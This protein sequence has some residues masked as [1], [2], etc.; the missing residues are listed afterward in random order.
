[1]FSGIIEHTAKIVDIHDGTFTIENTFWEIL[2]EGQSVAH[3]GACMTITRCDE[4][5]YD[6]FVMHESLDV[7]H[8]SS[9]K[10][11]DTFNIERSLR[12]G[13]RIDGHFVSGH[14]D[15]M[16]IVGNIELIPD[17]SKIVEV[18]FE[19]QYNTYIIRKG[20]ITINGVSL[21]IVE[22]GDGYLSVS[23]IPLTQSM[24][25]LGTLNVGDT[26]NL[27]FDTMAKYVQKMLSGSE[28]QGS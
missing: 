6:F 3:D 16:G 11:G 1:M 22:A 25:N 7:T 23:L 20:S 9:K 14:I 13:D 8:F 15:T 5:T 28:L 17:G 26:V 18:E 21:T 24:T 10:A 27:E 2:T 4:K 19:T 12:V